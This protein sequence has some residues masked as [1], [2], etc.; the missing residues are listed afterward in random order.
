MGVFYVPIVFFGGLG[1]LL[2]INVI[3]FSFHLQSFTAITLLVEVLMGIYV[4]VVFTLEIPIHWGHTGAGNPGAASYP[5][6]SFENQEVGNLRMCLVVL[7]TTYICL[8]N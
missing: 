5:S 1:F 8:A 2:G 7:Y 3:C 4:F 6:D